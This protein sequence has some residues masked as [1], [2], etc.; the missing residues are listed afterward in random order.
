MKFYMHKSFFVSTST[1]RLFITGA[2]AIF[3]H[4]PQ[5]ISPLLYMQ[6]EGA[7]PDSEAAMH[8]Q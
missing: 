6:T 1:P 7:S 2:G 4:A 5:Y 8:I 3:L